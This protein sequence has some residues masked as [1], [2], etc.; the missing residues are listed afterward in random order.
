VFE[1][2]FDSVAAGLSRFVLGWAVP[3]VVTVGIFAVFVFPVADRRWP[4]FAIKNA[5]TVS[6]ITLVGV[7][8]LTVLTLS[9][10]FA[11]SHSFI[12]RLLEGYTLPKYIWKPLYRRQ[13]RTW[14]LLQRM[15]HHPSLPRTIR[16]LRRES[17]LLYPEAKEDLQATRLGNALRALETYGVRRFGL[18]SQ[19]LWY[20]LIAAAPAQV[21]QDV[22]QTRAAVD[23]FVSSVAHFFLLAVTSIAIGI[24][25][26][27]W[28]AILVGVAALLAAWPAYL[29]A[30]RNVLGFRY[31]TQALIHMGRRPLADGLGFRLPPSAQQEVD[32]WVNLVRYVSSAEPRSWLRLDRFRVVRPAGP[33]SGPEDRA[34][35]G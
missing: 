34:A 30:V 15:A 26:G 17:R 35:D 25:T 19:T 10:L 2:V 3:S 18:N 5:A 24:W 32:L 1:K 6:G 11:Y 33:G 29:A 28:S 12:Y 31:A 22:E 9:M 20:E 21:K 23:L 14:S 4:F 8:G 13:V 16:Q 27:S 7:L